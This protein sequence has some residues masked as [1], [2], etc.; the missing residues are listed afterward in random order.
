MKRTAACLAG[1]LILALL[2]GCK[3][4][5]DVRRTQKAVL[6]TANDGLNLIRVSPDGGEDGHGAV[7]PETLAEG[8]G[9]SAPCFTADGRTAGYLR[10]DSLY[11]CSLETG[12]EELLLKDVLSFVP[13]DKGGFYAS[14][15][16]KG[17]V[18]VQMGREREEVWKP[19][20]V[21]GGWIQ[22]EKLALSPDGKKLAFAR[23]RYV[24]HREDPTL[25]LFEQ[26]QGIWM[27]EMNQEKEMG[28]EKGSSV[29]TRI[30]PDEPPFFARME[31]TGGEPY[32]YLWPAKWSPDSSRLFIWQDVLSG[33][34]RSDGIGAAVYDTVSASIIYPLAG[35]EEAVLPYDENV[36]FGEDNSLYL[37]VGAGREMAFDK[38]LVRIPP[39][40]GAVPEILRTPGLVPQ[41][42][43][44]SFDGKSIFFAASKELEPG[45]TVEYPIWR[46]LY[47]MEKG[48]VTELTNGTEYS[49][50]SPILTGDGSSLVFGRVDREGAMSIWSVGTDGSRLQKLADL[51][52]N[53]GADETNEQYP[54][55]Y[56]DF[57]GRGSW[58]SI[59][60]VYTS[61]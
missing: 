16:E 8:E 29:L 34:M 38:E 24:D 4:G 53:I 18:R 22:G 19:E 44:V 57:Y 15:R 39:E 54:A 27:I 3:G 60:A 14:S 1:L 37:L 35:Q 2:A 52:E 50:E 61:K 21:E 41:S 30:S 13:D 28:K 12:E 33:S 6:Y 31:Q 46:Q 56:E 43:R 11:G 9:I 32:P 25:S 10:Q 7:R 20:Q 42:P 59:M 5:A 40:T 48:N 17:I 26:N 49:S 58:N 55:G 47:R 23:R 36:V 45:K 51:K